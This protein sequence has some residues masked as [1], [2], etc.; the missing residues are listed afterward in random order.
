MAKNSL[1][2]K[3]KSKILESADYLFNLKGYENV[4]VEEIAEKSAVTKAMVYYHFDSKET[5]MLDLIKRLLENIKDKI[6]IK[7]L[8]LSNREI[9]NN[10]IKEMTG[11]WKSNREIGLFILTKGI[12]EEKIFSYMMEIL[13]LFFGQL[14]GTENTSNKEYMEQYIRLIFYNALP[15]ISF[16]VLSDIITKEMS[17]SEKMV[18]DIFRKGFMDNLNVIPFL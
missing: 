2:I 7:E 18:D 15:M 11:L 16:S 5:I 12:K 8:D 6:E 17:L 4:S 14:L 10:H 13:K 1:G 9:M 3:T